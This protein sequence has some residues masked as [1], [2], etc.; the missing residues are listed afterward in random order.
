MIAIQPKSARPLPLQVVW[1]NEVYVVPRG[2]RLLIGA[3]M[4]EV[5]FDTSVTDEAANWLSAR[6]IGL[7]PSLAT[8][9]V[10]ERWAGL[11]PAA[12]D[13]AP[14]LGRT[15]IDGLF[16]ASGQFRNGILFAPAVAEVVSRMVLGQGGEIAAFDPLRF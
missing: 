11:R 14:V 6:A 5:G 1:G 4:A 15:K 16:V 12:P 13:G 9:D 10:V 7:M 2:D 8:W 3:T